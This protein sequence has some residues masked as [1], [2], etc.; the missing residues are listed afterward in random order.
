MYN[1][2][3]AQYVSLLIW[4]NVFNFVRIIRCMG[5]LQGPELNWKRVVSLL[6][7]AA[8][9][10]V[11]FLHRTCA[12]VEETPVEVLETGF[13]LSPFDDIFKEY[14]DSLYDWKLLAAIADVES[15]FDTLKVSPS[16]AFGL[17]QV[18]P[19]TYRQMIGRLGIGDS[20]SVSTRLNVYAAVQQLSDMDRQFS[21][22]NKEERLNYVLASYNCGHGHV[23]DAMR[24]ARKEGINRYRWSNIE[25]VIGRMRLE[26]VY[27]DTVNCKFGKFIGDE[28]I[29][30]VRKVKK[31]YQEYC[32]L[33]SLSNPGA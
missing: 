7:S 33:D 18:M 28:T 9:I 20:D 12:D 21:F 26:E 1:I 24:I 6:A 16:G 22:I 19:A 8:I 15:S 11:L 30:Y 4:R 5:N 17:M 27:S 29:K 25:E 31:K 13:V 3:L 23:F 14:A 2:L 32:R 10:L